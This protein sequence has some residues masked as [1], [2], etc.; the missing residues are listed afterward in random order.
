[1]R[2]VFLGGT[3]FIGT[4]AVRLAAE[5]GHSV[6]VFHRG[7]HSS[8]LPDEVEE[9][10]VDRDDSPALSTALRKAS[11]DVVVDTFAMTKEQTRRTIDGLKDHNGHVVVLSSQDVYA[12]FGRLNGHPAST[13]EKLVSE[14]SPLTIP[15]PFKGIADHEGGSEY[16]KKDV[17]DLYANASEELFE[18][19]TILRLPAVFGT[20]DYR[21][22]FGSIVESLDAGVHRFPCQD[23]AGWRWTHGHVTNVAQAI[24]LAAEKGIGRFQVFNVGEEHP[25]TMRE[26]VDR[27]ARLTGKS[28]EWMETQDVPDELSILGKMP[29]DFVVTTKKIRSLLQYREILGEDECYLD[30]IE[31]I[32]RSRNDDRTRPLF[33]R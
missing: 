31:W 13:I 18:S 29:N 11:A 4:R 22:R 12:Q 10:V 6:G 27:I 17:E 1:M 33:E 28:V 8:V 9:V 3:R 16:D 30:L 14:S 32:R 23:Q 5:R 21:R 19:V 20:G 25:R 24:L 26:R 15:F 7:I 2:I